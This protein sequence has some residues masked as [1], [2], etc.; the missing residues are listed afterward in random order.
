MLHVRPGIT[1]II[2][3]N[4]YIRTEK[5]I[6]VDLWKYILQ[7]NYLVIVTANFRK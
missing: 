2:F 5:I 3:V 6:S 4:Y 7:Q 1:D